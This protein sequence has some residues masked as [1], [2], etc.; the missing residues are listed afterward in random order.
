MWIHDFLLNRGQK[1]MIK[2]KLSSKR[3]VT[4]G[5]PQGP[6]LGSILFLTY[7]NDLPECITCSTSLFA[8]DTILYQQVNNNEQRQIFQ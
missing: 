2:G 4:S 7:I 1:V 3:P 8:D 5:V 6:V